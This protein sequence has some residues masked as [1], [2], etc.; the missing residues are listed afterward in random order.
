[1]ATNLYL[2]LETPD[3]LLDLES[4][5]LVQVLLRQQNEARFGPQGVQDHL[6]R[7]QGENTK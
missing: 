7:R 6:L 3:V 1:M 5:E 4:E 2:L